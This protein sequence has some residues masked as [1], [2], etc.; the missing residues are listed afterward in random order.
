[1]R[2]FKNELFLGTGYVTVTVK[3]DR[4]IYNIIDRI[5]YYINTTILMD[6]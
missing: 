2:Y 5:L 6:S 4:I 3:S 1:M